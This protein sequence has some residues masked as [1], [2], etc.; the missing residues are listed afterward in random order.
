MKMKKVIAFILFTFTALSFQNCAVVGNSTDDPAE[1]A[2]LGTAE[3][4]ISQEKAMQVITQNCVGCHNPSN[5]QGGIGYLNDVNSLLYY[6]MIVPRDPG[7]S[8]LYQVIQSGSMPPGNPLS[9]DELAAITLW[10][11]EGFNAATP[12]VTA[13]VISNTLEPKFSNISAN[14]LKPKCLSCHS[15]D[16]AAGG[17]NLSTYTATRNVV[18]PGLPNS[19]VLYTAV[20]PGGKMAGRLTQAETGIIRDWIMAGAQNN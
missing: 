17:V 15:A 20:L 13:P 6:R 16:R 3:A 8:V 18:T 2:A 9:Q 1:L 10:I 7:S 11:T 19:S 12:V 4:L 14:I 5:P